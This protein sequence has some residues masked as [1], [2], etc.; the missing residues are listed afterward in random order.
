MVHFHKKLRYRLAKYKLYFITFISFLFA[1][2]ILSGTF[3]ATKGVNPH[4]SELAF[5]ERSIS[6]IGS[7]IPASCE[8]T[9]QCGSA[10]EAGIC[11]TVPGTDH[12]TT[13]TCWDGSVISSCSTCPVR[14]ACPTGYS[15]TY[16]NCVAPTPSGCGAGTLNDTCSCPSGYTGTYPNCTPPEP[17][18]TCTTTNYDYTELQADGCTIKSWSSDNVVCSN[19]SSLWLQG[20]FSYDSSSC[21]TPPPAPTPTPTPTPT[22]EPEP[23]IV[24]NADISQSQR[25]TIPGETFTI[26]WD[27]D[28]AD[29]CT[30]TYTGPDGGGTLSSPGTTSASQRASRSGSTPMTLTPLGSYTFTNTCVDGSRTDADSLTHDVVSPDLTVSTVTPTT[31]MIGRSVD[32]EFT[33]MN[34]GEGDTENSFYSFM[35]RATA[36]N[37]GGTVTDMP[38]FLVNSI[39]GGNDRDEEVSYTFTSVGTYS[40]RVCADKSDRNNAGTIAELNIA[41]DAENNNCGAWM[42]I[43]V[44]DGSCSLPWG[45]SIPNGSSVTAYSRSSVTSPASCSSY[46]Q[47]RRCTNSVLSGSYTHQSCSL[48]VPSVSVFNISPRTVERGGLVKINWSI[49][50]PTSACTVTAA[51]QRPATC[52]ATC[53]AAR[54]AAE[55]A[56]NNTLSNGTTNTNDPNGGN[57]DMDDALTD[58]V[59]GTY[60]KGEV[61]LS[62]D[63]S[64]TFTLG[65]GGT[66]TPAKSLIYVTDR[67]EG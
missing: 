23:V 59:S 56:L 12:G 28:L 48:A 3:F 6:A 25:E 18:V 44:T 57:R 4:V 17:D 45:G 14:P 20:P 19:N 66:M 62:L 34:M 64:T 15:G 13:Q 58:T 26:T 49:Q 46:D 37:G 40:M 47:T 33:I 65:C 30:V 29:Y 53:E 43:T 21:A 7:V 11:W 5:T 22:P 50:N 27:S 31:A 61:S 55:D 67:V 35:Q 54:D 63:Y 1:I 42:T 52:N 60:A 9:I 39:R 38:A 51:I 36:A 8:S 41:G 16:P 24:F 10:E 2:F 32:F